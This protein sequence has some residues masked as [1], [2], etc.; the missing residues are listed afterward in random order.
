LGTTPAAVTKEFLLLLRELCSWTKT[1]N[2]V[3]TSNLMS[4]FHIVSLSYGFLPRTSVCGVL[5]GTLNFK[6]SEL[7]LDLFCSVFGRIELSGLS[8]LGKRNS[9]RRVRGEQ[10]LFCFFECMLVSTSALSARMD[11]VVW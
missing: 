7:T 6:S 2:N 11:S 3:L 8:V 9:P 1:L 10:S 5:I 4:T